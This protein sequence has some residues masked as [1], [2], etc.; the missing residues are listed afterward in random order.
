MIEIIPEHG[1]SYAEAHAVEKSDAALSAQ[2]EAVGLKI[3]TGRDFFWLKTINAE[4]RDLECP[5]LVPWYDHAVEPMSDGEGFW[6]AFHD[7]YGI[8]GLIACRLRVVP[9]SLH[10]SLSDMTFL[11]PDASERGATGEVTSLDLTAMRGNMILP[12][13]MWVHPNHRGKRLSKLLFAVAMVEAYARW[14]PDHVIGL[15]ELVKE[16][17]IGF[18]SYDFPRSHKFFIPHVPG[19]DFTANDQPLAVMSMTQ[20]E[21]RERFLHQ[22]DPIQ[23][24]RTE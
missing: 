5:A 24:T 22:N 6:T 9:R 11:F 14:K 3:R 20:Q 15:V 1:L 19:L 8:A 7:D 16:N 18:H 4:Y 13:A 23:P 2:V 12:G 17:A 21:M 10:A